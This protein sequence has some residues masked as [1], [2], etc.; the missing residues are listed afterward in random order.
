MDVRVST[1]TTTPGDAIGAI[2]TRRKLGR[3]VGHHDHFFL[4]Q[5]LRARDDG[6]ALRAPP[7]QNTP[8]SKH[9]AGGVLGFGV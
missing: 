3:L 8:K 5:V 2:A 4:H 1:C 6:T 7:A 9:Q